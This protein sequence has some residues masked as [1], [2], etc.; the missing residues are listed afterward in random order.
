M[1]FAESMTEVISPAEKGCVK[2]SYV[3]V[4]ETTAMWSRLRDGWMAADEGQYARLHVNGVLMM[5]DTQK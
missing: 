4:D 5:T 2:L 3:T 1:R